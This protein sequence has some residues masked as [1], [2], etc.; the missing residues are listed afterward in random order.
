MEPDGR[1]GL[2]LR[3]GFRQIKALR[4]DDAAGSPP[5]AA[6]ATPRWRMSGAARAWARTGGQI[7]S[8]AL[9]DGAGDMRD[10]GMSAGSGRLRPGK[11]GIEEIVVF[12]PGEGAGVIRRAVAAPPL[13]R[14][15]SRPARFPRPP[16]PGEAR[17]L[18]QVAG[19]Q[20]PVIGGDQVAALVLGDH[21][22]GKARPGS[23]QNCPAPP[24]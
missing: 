19:E 4:E 9:H 13:A 5:P 17:L 6:T 10:P 20:P 15:P 18:H 2:A 16:R 22:E 23:G 1:G 14:I 3:L 24:P 11:P 7:M 12:Q 8:S 21:R